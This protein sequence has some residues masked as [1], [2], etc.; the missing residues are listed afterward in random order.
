MIVINSD[1]YLGVSDSWAKYT[2]DTY[3]FSPVIHDTM[4]VH[5]IKTVLCLSRHELDGNGNPFFCDHNERANYKWC[6]D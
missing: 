5:K 4:S 3:V 6:Q 2:G 1:I